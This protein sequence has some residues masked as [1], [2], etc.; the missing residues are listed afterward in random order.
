M[1]RRGFLLAGFAAAIGTALAPAVASASGVGASAARVPQASA[2]GGENLAEAD[3]LVPAQWGPPPGRG[4]GR[5][6]RR[7]RL[8]Q[9]RVAYRDRFGRTRYRMVTR[10]ICN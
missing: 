6:R 5:R 7:C 10:E 1:E 3:L 8:V 2:Q 9:R 4:R